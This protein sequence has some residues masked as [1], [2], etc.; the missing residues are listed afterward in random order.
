MFAP[1]S[2]S[3]NDLRYTLV[4][5][6]AP[7]HGGAYVEYTMHNGEVRRLPWLADIEAVQRASA[8]RKRGYKVRVSIQPFA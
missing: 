5:F 4:A 7:R 2:N 6:T 8:L 1:H 3:F